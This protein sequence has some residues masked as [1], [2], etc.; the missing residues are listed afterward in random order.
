VSGR[1]PR[2]RRRRGFTLIEMTVVLLI[3]A[4]GTALVVPAVQGGIESR[5]VRRAARQIASTM[6]FCRSEAVMLGE[7]QELV[8]DA[9]RNS[10]HTSGHGRWAILTDY[11]VIDSIDGGRV[12]GDGIVQILCFPNGSTSGARVVVAS[13][14]DPREQ[15]L[16]VALDPLLGTIR[17]TDG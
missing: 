17:V 8:L 3:I 6:L 16:L 10:V 9:V 12:A 11:A 15:R 7:P 1:R 2:A 4:V 5:E 13:R 14:R